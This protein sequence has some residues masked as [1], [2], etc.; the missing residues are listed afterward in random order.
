MEAREAKMI[1]KIK[2]Y[3]AVRKA[4]KRFILLGQ[5]IDSIDKAFTKKGVSRK[6]RR[7]FWYDFIKSP[8]SRQKFLKKMGDQ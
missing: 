1:K 4:R 5:M 8:E 7:Q 6:A 2:H 3:F